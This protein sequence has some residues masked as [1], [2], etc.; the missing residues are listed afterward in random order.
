MCVQN[1]RYV[2]KY[3]CA[4][5]LWNFKGSPLLVFQLMNNFWTQHDIIEMIL[6]NKNTWLRGIGFLPIHFNKELTTHQ[7]FFYIPNISFLFTKKFSF[8][9]F[10]FIHS[11]FLSKARFGNKAFR[12]LFFICAGY[13]RN[14]YSIV[15]SLENQQG[16]FKTPAIH[17]LFIF[18]FQS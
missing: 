18:H 13:F 12:E 2:T 5:R 6:W 16:Y 9:Y 7:T 8:I 1:K 10:L 3:R 17:D 14:I 4:I 11:L 15:S